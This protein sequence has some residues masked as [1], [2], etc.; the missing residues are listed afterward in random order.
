MRSK[1]A[2]ASASAWA[3]SALATTYRPSSRTTSAISLAPSPVHP[4]RRSE[5]DD[6]LLRAPG[7]REYPGARARRESLRW[8]ERERVLDAVGARQLRVDGERSS[9]RGRHGRGRARGRREGRETAAGTDPAGRM[10]GVA[11]IARQRD[12]TEEA[13]SRVA[14][15]HGVVVKTTSSGIAGAL[16]PFCDRIAAPGG[17]APLVRNPAKMRF[18][19]VATVPA[20]GSPPGGSNGRVRQEDSNE[21][22]PCGPVGPRRHGQR[23]GPPRPREGRPRARRRHRHASRLRRQGP[24]RGPRRRPAPRRHRDERPV[25]GP[26]QGEGRPRRHRDDLLDEGADARPEED[27]LGRDQLHL[28][29]RGDGGPRGA[30]PRARGRDRRPREEARRLDPRDR[31]Q[32]RLRPRPPRRHA[33]GRLPPGGQ[34]RGEPRERPHLPTA[35]PS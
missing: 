29:R 25:V 19:D 20:C 21:E 31:R 34:D 13:E 15:V 11:E 14:R 7:R 6:E 10:D 5:R 22:V 8:D 33:L 27:P 3:S 26:R 24:G 30:E 1:P 35:R 4:A 17:Y 2:D 12:D 32:P 23:H 9:R 28:H 18:P 16:R